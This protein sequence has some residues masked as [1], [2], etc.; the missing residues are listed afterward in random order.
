MMQARVLCIADNVVFCETA[1]SVFL[2]NILLRLTVF[3]V[4]IAG[5]FNVRRWLLARYWPCTS[6]SRKEQGEHFM[7]KGIK[8][9]LIAICSSI[10]V[11]FALVLLAFPYVHTYG[12]VVSGSTSVLSI[13]AQEVSADISRGTAPS[14]TKAEFFMDYKIRYIASG[15]EYNIRYITTLKTDYAPS[16]H[17]PV[18]GDQIDVVYNPVFPDNY[19]VVVK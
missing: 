18:P 19:R 6:P 13:E 16:R 15:K 8:A 10:V 17:F 9:A 3:K 11:I 7:S 14:L 1:K 5:K 2:C 12:T 4:N